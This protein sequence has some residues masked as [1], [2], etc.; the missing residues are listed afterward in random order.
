MKYTQAIKA[1]VEIET[2]RSTAVSNEP[3]VATKPDNI[4]LRGVASTIK[5]SMDMPK[6][7]LVRIDGSPKN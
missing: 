5:E 3:L 7:A 2:S 1:N 4:V 6:P